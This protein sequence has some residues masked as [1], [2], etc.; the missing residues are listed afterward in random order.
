[1]RVSELMARLSELPG[2]TE[3]VLSRDGE[4]NGYRPLDTYS[5]GH[6]VMVNR[7]GSDLVDH[8]EYL[9]D[10]KY[11]PAD[12]DG[13]VHRPDPCEP[14]PDGAVPGVVLWPNY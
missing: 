14:L 1:M 9:D 12:C 8:A 5:T 3:V 10:E 11:C 7:V 4:G 2:D 13:S 6:V